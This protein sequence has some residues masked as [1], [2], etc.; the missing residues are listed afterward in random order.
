LVLVKILI[1]LSRPKLQIFMGLTK[2]PSTQN[3]KI[4]GFLIAEKH[5]FHIAN[6]LTAKC[7]K[8]CLDL[9]LRTLLFFI[10]S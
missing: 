7:A 3:K 9:T 1:W 4:I 6:Y 5:G 2:K 8:L 10:K